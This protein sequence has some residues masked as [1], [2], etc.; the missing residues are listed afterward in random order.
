MLLLRYVHHSPTFLETE[1]DVHTDTTAATVTT[2]TAII[3]FLFLSANSAD[4]GASQRVIKQTKSKR[5][6]T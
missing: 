2:T 6:N 5:K 3:Q 4:T 1:S